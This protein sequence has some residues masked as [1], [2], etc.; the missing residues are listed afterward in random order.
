MK[1]K[2]VK[3]LF[4]LLLLLPAYTV[5]ARDESKHDTHTLVYMDEQVCKSIFACTDLF[6]DHSWSNQCMMLRA[7]IADNGNV[8]PCHCVE[9][10][11]NECLSLDPA[12]QCLIDYKQRLQEC[13]VSVSQ[14]DLEG[15]SSETAT[16][17]CGKKSKRF[18]KLCVCSLRAAQL[19]VTGDAVVDGDL[20]VAG[21]ITTDNLTVTGAITGPGGSPISAGVLG[22]GYI[23][24]TA[25][26]TVAIEAP[27]LFSDNGPLLGVTHAPGASA[28]TVTNAGTY[29]ILF[30]VSGVEPSQFT[31]FIN[32]VANT[33]T[34][35]GSG[36]GTQ[37]N[38]GHTIVTLAANDVITLVNHS[39]AAAVTLQTLAGG[40]QTNV[41]ASIQ[42]IRLA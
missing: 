8:A 36:A 3:L 22:Y 31:I 24:N 13:K 23:Y 19:L 21:T 27:V 25:A 5:Y 34:V 14:A 39:S 7:D 1:N 26:G 41:N 33:S 18:C 42:I 15:D 10:V 2:V 29:S 32:G 12:N 37:Q 17:G 28:I 38:T 9:S 20:A 4:A 40:T 16:R 35:Y 11:V 6:P 30:S